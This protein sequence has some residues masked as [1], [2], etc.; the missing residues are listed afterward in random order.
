MPLIAEKVRRLRFA[1]IGSFLILAGL[2]SAPSLLLPPP[3]Q[4]F[5]Q[6]HF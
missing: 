1:D 4:V 2:R 5:G 3:R 6:D